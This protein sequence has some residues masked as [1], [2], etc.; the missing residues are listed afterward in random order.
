MLQAIRDKVTGWIAYAII[1][2]ISVPFALWGVN[3]YLGGGEALPAATVN[4]E[5]IS[6]R[7][8]DI[9]YANYRQ[10]MTQVFGGS[11]PESLD[12]EVLLK[13]QA[14]TQLIE[15]TVLRTYARERGYRIGD[16]ELN[17]L[18]RSMDVFKIDGEFDSSIYQAQLRSQG[19]SSAG[20]E[21][22]L[23]QTQ[24]TEQL[25]TGIVATAFILPQSQTQFTYLS[26][27]TRKIRVLTRPLGAGSIVISDTE[28]EDYYQAQAALFMS[29]EQIK[30]D[31]LVLSLERVKAS[32]EISED[33]LLDRY[34]DT[35]D[36]FTSA[37][38]REA[39]HILLTLDEDA[40]QQESDGVR[41]R[42]LEIKQLIDQGGDFASLARE[43]SQD[44]GSAS[45]G[46]SLGEIEP[47]MM[48]QPFETALFNLQ[49]GDISDPVKTSFGWHLIKLDQIS[50]GG[51]KSFSAVRAELE[52]E[53]KTEMAES[54]IYD[55]VENLS[56]LAY[57]QS[58]S[59]L[60]AAEQFDLEVQTSD[61]FDRNTGS[62]IAFEPAVRKHAFSDDVLSQGLNS[63]AIELAD[64]RVVFVRL[65]QH[66][67]ASQK[68]LEQVRG[69]IEQRL[70]QQKGRNDNVETGKQALQN[71]LSGNTLDA[72]AA[73]WGFEI[74]ESD[75]VSRNSP[76][77]NPQLLT[78]AFTMKKPEGG[79]VFEGFPH[80]NGDYSLIE[81]SAVLSNDSSPD[82][83]AV[84]SFST[85]S[86]NLEYQ[87][88]IKALTNEAEV[89]KS[90]LEL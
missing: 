48:V 5:S 11:I 42:I 29:P 58:D 17:Q 41:G 37:E 3:S 27:Q 65:N 57:E 24:A 2:L 18:I 20:Y 26:N 66:R 13:D 88:V 36:A 53:V 46:G 74:I 9:A 21:Q 89:V 75:F 69:E 1:F 12:I 54:Q 7:D 82:K 68:S 77:F 45:E 32:I 52:D 78:R 71:L 59:L 85:A 33:L 90:P 47:G 4:G 19:Y 6:T 31:Y 70:K 39:S 30:I 8:L 34:E 35:K 28:I 67:S 38:F 50:G 84:K 40:S 55:M 25:Q 62:G 86:A 60:P 15:A 79:L 16:D 63:E 22:R 14:L 43:F 51:T 83:E 44:P 10:Q 49:A 64:N 61:W 80:G 76:E 23:R 87:S 81:L 72:I 56:N 73:D